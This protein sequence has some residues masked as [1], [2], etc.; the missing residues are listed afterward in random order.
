MLRSGELRELLAR[1]LPGALAPAHALVTGQ[2]GDPSRHNG[3][4]VQ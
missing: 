4:S 1:D 3:G 2:N